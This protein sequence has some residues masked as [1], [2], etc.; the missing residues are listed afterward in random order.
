M[1]LSEVSTPDRSTVT[2]FWASMR[3]WRASLGESR[4]IGV[5]PLEFSASR[6]FFTPPTT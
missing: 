5:P 6:N 2:L 3:T 1:V 4:S